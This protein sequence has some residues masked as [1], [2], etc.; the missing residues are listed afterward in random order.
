[1]IGLRLAAALPLHRAARLFDAETAHGLAVRALATFNGAHAPLHD[2]ALGIT[3]AGLRLPSPIGLA[4][5]F[6]KNAE[7]PAAALALGFGFAE[8]GTVTPKAQPGNA[9]PRVFR[10]PE[11]EGLINRLGFNNQGFGPAL[12]RLQ[13]VNRN[14]VIGVNVGANKDSN[15]RVGD[16]VSGIATFFDVAD[17]FTVNVS[18][19]NTPG[20]RDLQEASAMRDLLARVM[21]KHDAL[22]AH[23]RP[24]VFVKIAPDMDDVSHEAL[25]RVILESGAHGMIVS[26]TTVSR[27]LPAKAQNHAE[28]GGLS[29]KPLFQLSTRML[30]RTRRI[31]G[32][33]FPLIAAGGVDCGAAAVE[34]IAAG[35]DAVQLYSALAWHGFGLPARINRAVVHV[36]RAT[37]L[38]QLRGTRTAHW[39]EQPAPG[40]A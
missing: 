7:V 36:A 21:D 27:P 15:D 8:I 37:P 38:T 3:L 26:N 34:K 29:G 22:A 18:S 6:D 9:R 31:V 20:L 11:A 25:T 13:T 4:A 40:Y 23:H 32:P 28:T 5:G 30:A 35:A 1:M 17:Y 39:A 2:P 19:P 12:A 33:A 14:G 16:Y 24:P 10:V